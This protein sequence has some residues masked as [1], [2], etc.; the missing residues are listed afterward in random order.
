MSLYGES[1]I[2]QIMNTGRLMAGGEQK[3]SSGA[4]KAQTFP[5]TKGENV[6]KTTTGK[7]IFNITVLIA[8]FSALSKLLGV[9]RDSVIAH[10]FGATGASDAYLVALTAPNL[11][12]YIISGA[13]AAVTVPVFIEYSTKG[14]KQEAWKVFNTV[15]NAVTVVFIL[16]AAAGMV[17][18]P[19]IVKLIAWN[20]PGQTA[21]L[22]ASL[23]RIMFPLLLFAGWASLFAGLLNANNIFGIP[24]SSNAVNN[25]VIILGAV[26]LGSFYGV[27]GLAVGTVIAMAAMALMQVPAL[28][29]AGYRYK[30]A[31]DLSHPG[32]KQVFSLILPAAAGLTVNQAYILIEKNIASGMPEGTIT[33]LSLANKLVQVPISL[34]VLA[35][36]TAVFPTLTKLVTAGEREEFSASLNRLLRILILGMVPASIGLIVLRYPIVSLL[37]KSGAFDQRATEMTAAALLFYSVGLAGQAANAILTKAFYS[38]QDTKTPVKITLATVLVNL[39][40]S[41]LL[42][43]FLQHGGLALASSLA[44]LTGT[45]LFM[46]FIE[47]K[48]KPLRWTGLIRFTLPVLAASALMAAASYGLNDVLTGLFS[49][50][51]KLGLAV[52]VG[53]S[54]AAGVAVFIAAALILKIEELYI[55]RNYLMAVFTGG[56]QKD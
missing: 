9:L 13:L 6:E 38:L 16:I 47:K 48:V 52:Q 23:A 31:L 20:L 41:L 37:Y 19:C 2:I 24:A 43:R 10:K 5:S 34:F 53:S 22:A 15:F 27:H 39:G 46:F 42:T 50:H 14:K 12:F 3:E 54:V 30:P 32:V 26:T 40:L 11:L 51:G 8:F 49:P 35:L 7:M 1:V 28:L 44:S 18:S 25:V 17:F 36:G 21:N 4:V 33:A 45:A 55:L 29:R 56:R